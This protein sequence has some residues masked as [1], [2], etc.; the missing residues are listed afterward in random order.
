[1]PRLDL[2]QAEGPV[3]INRQPELVAR[4]LDRMVTPHGRV[5]VC[6]YRPRGARDAEPIGELLRG[7]GFAVGGEA[8]AT[9]PT[10]GGAA[11]RVAWIDAPQ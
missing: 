3:P 11:T 1:M 9:D 6:A 4:L 8:M 10:D 7:W 5:I 2:F